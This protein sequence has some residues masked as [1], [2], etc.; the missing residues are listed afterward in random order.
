MVAESVEEMFLSFNCMVLCNGPWRNGTMG[1]TLS[2]KEWHSKKY[3]YE[4]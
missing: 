1:L 4:I 3:I 2:G